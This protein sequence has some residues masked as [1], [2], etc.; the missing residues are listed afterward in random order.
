MAASSRRRESR[1]LVILSNWRIDYTNYRFLRERLANCRRRR[2]RTIERRLRDERGARCWILLF[3]AR[4][5]HSPPLFLSFSRPSF[6]SL[7]PFLP[8]SSLRSRRPFFLRLFFSLAASIVAP[9]G[10]FIHPARTTTTVA[11]YRVTRDASQPRRALSSSLYLVLCSFSFRVLSVVLHFSFFLRA[12]LSAAL[13]ASV[14]KIEKE[15]ER[16]RIKT[17]RLGVAAAAIL[18]QESR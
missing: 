9:A 18:L 2:L 11:R 1:Y 13:S 6:L 12:P 4:I 14:R 10:A 16:E 8:L 7:S 15:R 17:A 5:L 3:L